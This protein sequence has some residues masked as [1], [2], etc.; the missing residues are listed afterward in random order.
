[1][2]NHNARQYENGKWFA[3][4]DSGKKCGVC[5][6]CEGHDTKEEAVRHFWEWELA[7]RLWSEA[8]PGGGKCIVC[9]ERADSEACVG[10]PPVKYPL[11]PEHYNYET[12]EKLYLEL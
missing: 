4:D 8:I 1:M 5:I 12:V 7:T 3:C 10:Y 9:G 6:T 2:K 11:C